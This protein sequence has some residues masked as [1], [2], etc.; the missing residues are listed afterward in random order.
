MRYAVITKNNFVKPNFL[1]VLLIIIYTGKKLLS[2]PSLF[3]IVHGQVSSYLADLCI[4]FSKI[5]T[6]APYHLGNITDKMQVKESKWLIKCFLN[7]LRH[8]RTEC[9][10]LFDMLSIFLFPTSI[11]FGFLKDFYIV[12]VCAQFI[13]NIYFVFLSFPFP[14]ICS[15]IFTGDCRYVA[16]RLPRAIYHI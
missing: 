15:P 9:N 8:D 7:Y 2:G 5:H 10:L 6:I 16:C 11:N 14:T 1:H 13:Y 3:L 12:E 4:L